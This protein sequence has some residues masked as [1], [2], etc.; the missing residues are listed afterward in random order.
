VLLKASRAIHL[1]LVAQAIIES[2]EN[3]RA[4]RSVRKKAG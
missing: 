4:Q 3:K 2:H 1:E